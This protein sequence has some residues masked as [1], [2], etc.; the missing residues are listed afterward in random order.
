MDIS[1]KIKS[2]YYKLYSACAIGEVAIG[3]TSITDILAASTFGVS[4][5]AGYG[6]STSMINVIY[7]ACTGAYTMACSEYTK[8]KDRKIISDYIV[9]SLIA[10]F[11]MVIVSLILAIMLSITSGLSDEANSLIIGIVLIRGVGGFTYCI[12]KILYVLFRTDGYMKI[13]S[14]GRI[15]AAGLNVVFDLLVIVLHWNIY[16]V[17]AAT[18]ISE[19]GELVYLIICLYFLNI[20]LPRPNIKLEVE[21]LKSLI[22]LIVR[23]FSLRFEDALCGLAASYLG[24]AGYAVYSAAFTIDDTVGMSVYVLNS[25]GCIIYN[26]YKDKKER[27]KGYMLK[28]SLK[29][30]FVVSVIAFVVSPLL[31]KLLAPSGVIIDFVLLNTL[32][33]SMIFLLTVYEILGGITVAYGEFKYITKL[34]FIGMIVTPIITYLLTFTRNPYITIMAYGVWYCIEAYLL[35]KLIKKKERE[36]Q[37]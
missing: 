24:D 20:K 32:N 14:T 26:E 17:A 36:I 3:I 1:K 8:D 7:S 31:I 21:K 16:W 18:V 29:S 4:E 25:V 2:H 35:N 9:K 11:I 27:L 15:V 30:S 19:L 23:E 37:R 10:Q 33:L 34:S 6:L 5:F 22:Y 13:A 12:S 28:L